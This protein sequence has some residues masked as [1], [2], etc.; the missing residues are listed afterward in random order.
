MILTVTSVVVKSVFFCHEEPLKKA[1]Y[2]M[3]TGQQDN[4]RILMINVFN[5][6]KYFLENNKIKKIINKKTHHIFLSVL[7]KLADKGGVGVCFDI[8]FLVFP[9]YK[10]VI[11]NPT[12]S[13]SFVAFTFQQ[14]PFYIAHLIALNQFLKYKNVDG[15]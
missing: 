7:Y 12:T 6:L 13:P 3:V 1:T 2:L 15:R 11:K 5:Y 8:C 10:T 9:L 4:R 14:A